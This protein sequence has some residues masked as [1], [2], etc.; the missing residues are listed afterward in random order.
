VHSRRWTPDA[1]NSLTIPPTDSSTTSDDA[2]NAA[3]GSTD[4]DDASATTE[5][6]DSSSAADV[7]LAVA[8]YGAAVIIDE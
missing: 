8:A 2:T 6:T 1:A 7:P 4:A 5:P 3:D